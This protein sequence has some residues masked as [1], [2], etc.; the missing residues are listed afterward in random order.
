MVEMTLSEGQILTQNF[1]FRGHISTF[2]AENTP[3]NESFK[4]KNNAQTTSE[5]PKNNFQ[6]VQRTTFL[7]LKM[8]KTT[9]SA[10]QILTQKFE[11]NISTFRAENTHKIGRFKAENNAYTTSEHPQ[12]NFQKVQKTTFLAP[13]MY[14]SRVT[15]L[16]KLL[17]FG[18]TLDLK[19]QILPQSA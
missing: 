17:I 7:T 8:V 18:C 12:N 1:D 15:I 16:A 4:A 19:S 14:K 11:F 6:K 3:K 10:G 2:R 5:H 13:K 9:L